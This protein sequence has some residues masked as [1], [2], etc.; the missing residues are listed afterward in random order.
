MRR[1]SA[2]HDLRHLLLLLPS[3]DLRPLMYWTSRD[4]NRNMFPRVFFLLCDNT[5]NPTFRRAG[6]IGEGCGK[7]RNSSLIREEIQ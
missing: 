5:I 3:K 6:S 4:A 2:L 7:R 1:I